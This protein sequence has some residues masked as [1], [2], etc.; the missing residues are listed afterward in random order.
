MPRQN[1]AFG[2]LKRQALEFLLGDYE[3]W[4][5]CFHVLASGGHH[6]KKR[7]EST[8]GHRHLPGTDSRK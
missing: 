2:A 4:G 5:I 1:H 6:D 3:S 7:N 8:L